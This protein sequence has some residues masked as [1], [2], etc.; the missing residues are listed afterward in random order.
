MIQELTSWVLP[1][2]IETAETVI[3]LT[4]SPINSNILLFLYLMTNKKTSL[5]GLSFFVA[6]VSGLTGGFGLYSYE[7][8]IYLGYLLIYSY[9]VYL[10]L[11]KLKQSREY[12][13]GKDVA[14]C[15][16]ALLILFSWAIG[17]AYLYPKT[18]TWFYIN[19][20]N[21]LV[22]LHVCLIFAFYKPRKLLNN[23]GRFIYGFISKSSS[24]YF[25]QH[26]LYTF[27]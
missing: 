5:M 25:F 20:A 24:N 10:Q 16:L 1:K 17:D 3:A 9:F 18:K 23:M 13:T 7:W 8:H 6:E 15:S 4:K 19:Y 12:E 21:I 22:L 2:A 14:L 11:E 27:R 26:L